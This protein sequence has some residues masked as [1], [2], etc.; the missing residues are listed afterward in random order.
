MADDNGFHYPF[1]PIS[2]EQ[3]AQQPVQQEEQGPQLICD[4]CKKPILNAEEALNGLYGVRGRSTRTGLPMVL[5]S[6]DIPEGAFD[7]HYVCL[8][9]FIVENLPE[10]ADDVLAIRE[11]EFDQ[12]PEDTDIFCSNCD[13]KIKWD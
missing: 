1:A 2:F 9:A 6:K 10:T 4:Y 12:D 3:P 11:G 13:E 8:G 5:P 7:V